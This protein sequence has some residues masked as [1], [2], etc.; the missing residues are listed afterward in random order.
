MLGLRRV[1]VATAGS[2]RRFSVAAGEAR[3]ALEH[4]GEGDVRLDRNRVSKLDSATST[5]LQR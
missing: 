2:V 4:V 3:E 5:N 1:S